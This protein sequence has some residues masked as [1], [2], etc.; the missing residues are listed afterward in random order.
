MS[1]NVYS[2]R[3]RVS[4]LLVV[5][6][7]VFAASC[8]S[9]K[10]PPK[11]EPADQAASAI[12]NG[13]VDTTHNAVV[14]IAVGDSG[15]C[16]G[17]IVKVDAATKIGWVLTAAHC[18]VV[19]PLIVIQASDLN[20]PNAVTYNVIDYTQDTRYLQPACTTVNDCPG[21]QG[22][23]CEPTTHHCSNAGQPYDFA[24]VRIAGADATTP[25]IPISGSPD[26]VTAGTAVTMVGYGRT[27]LNSSGVMDMNTQRHSFD[28][29]VGQ[30]TTTLL[31]YDQSAGGT[32]QGDS[33]GPDITSGGKV[34]GVH[35]FIEGDCNQVSDSGRLTD[36]LAYINGELGKAAPPM[37]CA[38]C[39]SIANSG[40][41]QCAVLSRACITDP[42]CGA[43]YKCFQGCNQTSACKTMCLTKYPKAEGPLNAASSC[44]CNRACVS[45]CSGGL[46]CYGVPKCGYKFPAG[47]CATC[48]DGACCQEALDC[49]ADGT[50][51]L[52]LK[53]GDKDPACVTNAKRQALATCVAKSCNNECANTGLTNGADAGDDGGT[54][55]DQSSSGA[56]GATA[57]T[58]SGCSTSPRGASPSFFALALAALGLAAARRR[59]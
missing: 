20:D 10:A 2:P 12:I 58:T 18:V 36:D 25:V 40:N 24:V 51:Y 29:S 50:C 8:S 44:S 31:R 32:C 34:V 59:R 11:P 17:T 39:T 57:A 26:G 28:A 4:R 23:Q 9:T 43:F 1:Q 14:G 30:V 41:Q 3:M 38:L 42:D 46:A 27:T 53:N 56:G 19:A 45:E 47:A 55:D 6:F 37:D 15:L 7:L 49:G 16:S 21:T 54:G 48:T 35:S 33:G 52:C 13:Q 5:P 22:W